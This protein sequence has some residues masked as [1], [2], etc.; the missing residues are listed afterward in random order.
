MFSIE[1]GAALLLYD[2]LC[3]SCFGMYRQRLRSAGR[4]AA[5]GVALVLA[6]T[7]GS[8]WAGPAGDSMNLEE[9]TWTE[10]KAKIG[11]GETTVL[12]PIGG[13]EQNGPDI[14]LGK[15]N[16]R[17]KA[18]A[19]RIAATLGNVIVA[20]VISYVPEGRPD[21]PE[22]HMRFPGTITVSD[23]T[24]EH[25]L[26]SAARSFKVHG[27]RDIV[28]I[29]DHGGYQADERHVAQRLNREW[30]ATGVRVHAIEEYYRVTRREYL[31]ELKRRGFS[32]AEIGT[33]AG[34]AD[35][36]LTLALAP[37]LVRRGRLATDPPAAALGE[38]GDPRRATPERG[39]IGADLIVAHTVAAIREAVA[40]R[41]PSRKS[42][43]INS[44]SE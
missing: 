2:A 31:D 36:S 43:M 14:A 3:P 17:V 21:P 39:E 15:H 44:K 19:Q 30:G 11:A 20:P 12:V 18:L 10:L 38:Y 1:P 4:V 8:A 32:E 6:C 7:G 33:H 28:F 42:G 27:F 5:A 13:T 40:R 16:A 29:G 37:E 35:A 23:D 24:F 34:L 22:Q 9:L 26:E 25:L 41:E